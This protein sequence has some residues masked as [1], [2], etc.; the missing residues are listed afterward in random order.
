MSTKIFNGL[1]REEMLRMPESGVKNTLF[2]PASSDFIKFLVLPSILLIIF[3]ISYYNAAQDLE[4]N[5]GNF[6]PLREKGLQ[7]SLPVF[8]VASGISAII[9]LIIFVAWKIKK[10][11][12]FFLTKIDDKLIVN[13]ENKKLESIEICNR[14]R[15]HSFLPNYIVIRITDNYAVIS[16]GAFLQNMLAR[17]KLPAKERIIMN[18][19]NLTDLL[20][21]IKEL[22]NINITQYVDRKIRKIYR[23]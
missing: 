14:K 23:I 20:T 1:T 3:L 8:L 13:Y 4:E 12:P 7:D 19:N 10:S 17:E 18:I 15:A 22:E 2:F 21:F 11:D 6:M 5:N 9:L 16:H